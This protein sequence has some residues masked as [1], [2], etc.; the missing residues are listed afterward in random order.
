MAAPDLRGG[1]AMLVAAL[2]ADGQSE[3]LHMERVER[4]YPDLA[5]KLHTLD[6]SLHVVE[7]LRRAA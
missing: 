1:F 2:V 3:I 5:G 7:G 6:A 4:G